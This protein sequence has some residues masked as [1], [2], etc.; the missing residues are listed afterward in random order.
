MRQG[1][2][3]VNKKRFIAV[4]F[5]PDKIVDEIHP[6]IRAI[7][8]LQLLQQLAVLKRGRPGKTQALVLGVPGM[9]QA[10]LVEAGV[11]DLHA[12]AAAQVR[13]GVTGWIVTLQLPFARDAGVIAGLLQ[14]MTDRFRLGIQSA[15]VGPIAVVVPAGH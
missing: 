3:V 6:M 13:A 5:A 2:R 8:A 12:L 4:L 11:G 1:H 9:K 14:I 15:E 10:V 7:L